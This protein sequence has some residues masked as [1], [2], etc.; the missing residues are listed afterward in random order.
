MINKKAFISD[1]LRREYNALLRAYG[2]AQTEQDLRNVSER[3]LGFAASVISDRGDTDDT[4]MLGLPV[5]SLSSLEDFWAS[6]WPE[7]AERLELAAP[8]LEF[9]SAPE[10]ALRQHAS[11]MRD[12]GLVVLIKE[13]SEKET[14]DLV[15]VLDINL[16]SA[17]QVLGFL[18]HIALRRPCTIKDLKLLN[19]L[20][21]AFNATPGGGKGLNRLLETVLL[22][23]EAASIGENWRAL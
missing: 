3:A 7:I 9:A 10:E 16:A 2:T 21:E 5:L 23:D 11:S 1:I 6:G 14:D 17:E 12:H 4:K 19:E 20:I 22:S 13:A 8:S 15:L 18:F